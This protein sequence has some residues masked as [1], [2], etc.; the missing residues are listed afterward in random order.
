MA[1][2]AYTN[3]AKVVRRWLGTSSGAA[4][5]ATADDIKAAAAELLN[6]QGPSSKG[7]SLLLNEPDVPVDPKYLS[8]A[9]REV[10]AWLLSLAVR[11]LY[12]DGNHK[13]SYDLAQNSINILVEHLEG[14]AVPTSSSS[15]L[16]PLLSR[17]YR[18]RAL[19]AESLAD[20][21]LTSTLQADMAKAHSMATIRR[22]V[23]TQATMLN[24]MLRDLLK[25]SQGKSANH[26]YVS[27][28]HFANP[29]FQ[30]LNRQKSCCLT[31]RSQKQPRIINIVATSTTVVVFKLFVSSTL[32]HS[33][34]SANAC[35]RLRQTRDLVSVSL[36]NVS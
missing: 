33:L 7:R 28:L 1:S 17:I 18:L 32:P 5:D 24:C 4:G 31:P 29:C 25:Q 30:Q 12:K 23:D 27:C 10:E 2:Y 14:P 6:P 34:I 9:E 13:E 15:A 21:S 36:P 8:V 26:Y 16:F 19:A 20:P 11:V 3:P 35:A 22:D